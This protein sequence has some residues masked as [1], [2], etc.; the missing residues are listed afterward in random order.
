VGDEPVDR[1]DV[2]KEEGK[3]CRGVTR[4]ATHTQGK[5]LEG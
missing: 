3:G 5:D 4:E 1:T 2:F